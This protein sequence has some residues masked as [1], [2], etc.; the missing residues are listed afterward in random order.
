MPR[1]TDIARRL[2]AAGLKVVEV[3]G[4]QT[5]G[6]VTFHPRGS[7]DHHTAGPRR[8][9][10]PS[11][12]VCINGRPDLPGPLCHVLVGRDLTC[13]L[14]AA[15]RANHAGTGGWKGLTGNSSVYGVERENVGTPV[16]PWTP[17]QT[18]HAAT[19]HRALSGGKFTPNFTC[20]HAEWAP[21]R[22]VDTHS[23]SGNLLRALIA[24]PTDPPEPPDPGDDDMA[25]PFSL[26]RAHD[27]MAVYAVPL[28][29]S[30]RRHVPDK[31]SLAIEQFF[32]STYPGAADQVTVAPAGPLKT[33]LKG[34]PILGD[35]P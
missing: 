17:E 18:V 35:E 27:E 26:W 21:R 10:A 4:W 31:D 30:G 7:V 22:K 13:Y 25:P 1:D 32:L 14:I 28:D 2:R 34:L 12:G 33:W 19:V 15:G 3:A 20:R 6:S 11:L 5:R 29:H 23:I 16:E 8:G 24:K 9:N